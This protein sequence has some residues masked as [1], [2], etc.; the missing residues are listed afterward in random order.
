MTEE[1][2]IGNAEGCDRETKKQ[3]ERKRDLG[4]EIETFLGS[5]D[6][7]AHA[8][9]EDWDEEGVLV[10]YTLRGSQEEVFFP[11]EAEE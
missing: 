9:V 6:G 8:D 7:S 3:D 2:G 5:L 1:K 11:Y 4:S 10:T